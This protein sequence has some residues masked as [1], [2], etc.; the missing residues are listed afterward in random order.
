MANANKKFKKIAIIY[1]ETKLS[2]EIAEKLH[3]HC[4]PT[5]PQEADLIIVIGGDGSMLHALHQYMDLKI[6]FYGINCGS[7]GFLMNNFHPKNFLT[8]IQ[9]A[10]AIALH[11]LEMTTTDISGKDFHA[12]AI[13]EVSL[14]RRTNQAAKIQIK[15][16]NIERLSELTA[17]GIL[18][19]TPAGSSAYNLSAGGK[20]VPLA[21]NV[22][23]L[24]PICP[25]RPRRWHGAI[26]PSK[27]VIEFNIIEPGKRTVNAVADFNEFPNVKKIM[28]KSSRDKA[29]K[30]L[31]DR[32]YTFEDRVIKEQFSY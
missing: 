17:D 12:L 18:V 3:K 16:N 8:N 31:F 23:C 10:Q 29:I 15:V 19:A 32:N 30:I 7:V 11:P 25:F 2:I 21:S 5:E 28:V 14:F 6:P 1:Q 13:N 9:K 22:L 26:L 27:V 24:T 4:M 20:I